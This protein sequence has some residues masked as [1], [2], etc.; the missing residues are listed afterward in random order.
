MTNLRELMHRTVEHDHA[1]M[2]Q[3]AA[4]ARSRGTSL[5]RRRRLA[6][7]GSSLAVVAVLMGGVVTAGG[8]L[9]GEPDEVT[10]VAGPGSST[11][12]AKPLTGLEALESAL[13]TVVPGGSTSR[14]TAMDEHEDPQDGPYAKDTLTFTPVSGSAP[15]VIDVT[16]YPADSKAEDLVGRCDGTQPNCQVITL[17]DGSPLQTYDIPIKNGE[18]G[19]VVGTNLGAVRLVAG[20]VV[21]LWVQVPV[22]EHDEVLRRTTALTADQLKDVMS[23]PEWGQ[24]VP[25]D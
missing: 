14:I 12:A 7:A 25:L 21:A 15:S 22:D 3:L 10:V 5:R 24:L 23:Q 18:H 13:D 4:R 1:D 19:N 2:V 9:P 6:V 20:N 11:S 16:Y 17:P 8:L